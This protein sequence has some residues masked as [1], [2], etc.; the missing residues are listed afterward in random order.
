MTRHFYYSMTLA[1]I[2]Q[3]NIGISSTFAN[4]LATVARIPVSLTAP[5][6]SFE[7]VPSKYGGW[8]YEIY[9]DQKLYIVQPN[10]PAIA[11]NKG[12]INKEDAQRVAELILTK[13]KNNELPPT[14]TI[15]ELNALHISY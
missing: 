14:V 9:Q 2:V 8:G 7:I 10:I 13:I 11:G 12:F 4:T 15:E 5:S 3:C 1:F 6:L